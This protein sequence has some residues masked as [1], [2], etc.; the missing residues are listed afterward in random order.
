MSVSKPQESKQSLKSTPSPTQLP[1]KLIIDGN[2]YCDICIG[3]IEQLK[4]KGDRSLISDVSVKNNR[5]IH[6]RAAPNNSIQLFLIV[7][8]IDEIEIKGKAIVRLS[9][10]NMKGLKLKCTDQSNFQMAGTLSKLETILS[11]SAACNF[12]EVNA[13]LFTLKLS[14]NAKLAGIGR[15]QTANMTTADSSRVTSKFKIRRLNCNLWDES[16]LQIV[17][18]ARLQK[19]INGSSRLSFADSTGIFSVNSDETV[20]R[21]KRWSQKIKTLNVR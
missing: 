3:E 4:I 17:E 13:D 16:E 5:I 12:N 18:A 15:F 11:D 14:D 8:G 6:G 1:K 10:V 2:I 19:T 7:K 9:K 20:I 21:E